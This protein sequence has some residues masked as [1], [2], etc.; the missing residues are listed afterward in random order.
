M[1]EKQIALIKHRSINEIRGNVLSGTVKSKSSLPEESESDLA[2]ASLL[3]EV[4]EQTRPTCPKRSTIGRSLLGTLEPAWKRYIDF[5]INTLG[6]HF[7]KANLEDLKKQTEVEPD[8]L[9]FRVLQ[10]TV[11][12]FKKG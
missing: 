12:F 1:D 9:R 7:C 6:C 2:T 8:K 11:G 3:S 10:S 4:W 5:H